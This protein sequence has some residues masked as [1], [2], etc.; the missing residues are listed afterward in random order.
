MVRRNMAFIVLAMLMLAGCAGQ[1]QDK[2]PKQTS[3]SDEPYD[4]TINE[5]EDVIARSGEVTNSEKLDAFVSGAVDQVRVVRF[6]TEGNPI[7]YNLA[8]A[9]DQIEV[10]YD[11]SQ[12]QY[13]SS[14]V[15]TYSCDGLKKEESG[16]AYAYKLSGCGAANKPIDLLDV[17]I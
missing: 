15:K 9:E 2:V 4:Y 1:E 11:T 14:S 8:W 17:P 6:I 12:D 13:G 5:I 10:R 3:A 16:R 7:F